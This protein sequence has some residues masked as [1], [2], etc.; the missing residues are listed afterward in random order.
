MATVA[1]SL[2][3]DKQ[4]TLISRALASPRRYAM[5]KQISACPTPLA[6]SALHEHHRVSAATVS[7]HVKEL[8]RAG[9]IDVVHEGKFANLAV[10][11]DVWRAYLERL[12]AI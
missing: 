2:L 10:R 1:R 11:R 6:C 3:S 5:L 4:F 8:E 9:L 7:H 12:A